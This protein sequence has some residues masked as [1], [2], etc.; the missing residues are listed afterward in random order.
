MVDGILI[1]L[2]VLCVAYFIVIVVYAGI[3]TSFAFIWLFFAALLLF[4]VYGRWYYSRNMDRIPRWVP[5]S[6]VTTCVAG[7]VALAVLCVL[8]FLGA[9]SSDK[10]NLDYVI[11]LGARVKEHT[12]SNSLKKRL[13]KAIEYAEENPDTILVLS[14]GRGPGED[15]S[16]AEVMR[17]YLEYNGVRPEQL[18]IEDR[19]VSTVENIA[20]SKVVIEEHRNRDKKELVPLTRRTTSVPYAIAPDK[21]LEIGVLTSNFHI[22]RARLTAEKWG[23]ENVYGISA[24]SDPVLFIHLCVRECAS[25]VKDRLMGNM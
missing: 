3:G 21:P 22:Y 13:D 10:K 20:Y 23:I 4:L 1:G 5:V 15:V 19:S 2:G 11:V 18:L 12:V 17:Q 6:V 14:G 24:D 9:A 7:V 8:V 25:I 16:E